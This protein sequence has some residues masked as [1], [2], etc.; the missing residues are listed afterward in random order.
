MMR[1][2]FLKC[3]E[4]D[5]L[6]NQNVINFECFLKCLVLLELHPKR[7]TYDEVYTI[8]H[9]MTQFYDVKVLNLFEFLDLML[10]AA[11]VVINEVEAN[12]LSTGL[13]TTENDKDKLRDEFYDVYIEK[14]L[15]K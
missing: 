3:S 5:Q 4:R 11:N 9:N 2:V 14:H 1:K 8:F 6:N 10:R 15:H 13:V 12:Q 7:I